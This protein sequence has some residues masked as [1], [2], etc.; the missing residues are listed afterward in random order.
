MRGNSFYL[1]RKKYQQARAE[2]Q[3][4]LAQHPND[5]EA[6]LVLIDVEIADAH[7][8]TTRALINQGLS[9][10]PDDPDFLEKRTILPFASALRPVRV[11]LPVP[12]SINI[13]LEM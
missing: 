11:G 6:L 7:S 12:G 3:V 10:Y 4:I 5:K 13:R 1:E 2:F 9:I 8:V